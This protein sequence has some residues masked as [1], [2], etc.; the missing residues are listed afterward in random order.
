MARKRMIDPEIWTDDKV[1]M[2]PLDAV[3][4][5]IGLIT[6]AD[7]EGRLKYAPISL[8][9]KICPRENVLLAQVG[10]WMY[11][12]AEVGL[13]VPYEAE[14]AVFAVLPGWDRYQKVGH[15]VP[16]KLP[17]PPDNLHE[18]SRKFMKIHEDSRTFMSPHESSSQVRLGKVRLSKVRLGQGAKTVS[19]D[20]PDFGDLEA[21]AVA[22]IANAASENKT[23]KISPG[24][25]AAL[26]R[27]L[28]ELRAAFGDET[29]SA[30]LRETN[31]KGIANANYV[32]RVAESAQ[33]RAQ[34]NAPLAAV[35]RTVHAYS[36]GRKVEFVRGSSDE[37]KAWSDTPPLGFKRSDVWPEH[38]HMVL[39]DAS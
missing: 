36:D 1:L 27:E 19:P 24:R 10:E 4:F 25:E 13:V 20:K 3:A 5:Y 23:G 39:D 37:P 30:A 31:R 6:Q 28:L 18:A 34:G 29:F 16:S 11:Q 14:N 35:P 7:D 2:L 38:R 26:R 8:R 21:D 22:Y 15:P 33:K 32:K 9:A 12:I 17:A